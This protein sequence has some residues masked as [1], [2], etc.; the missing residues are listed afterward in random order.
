MAVFTQVLLYIQSRV[1]TWYVRKGLH[2]TCISF[3][4]FVEWL[5]CGANLIKIGQKL[6]KLF[7]NNLEMLKEGRNDR[8]AENSIPP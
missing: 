8:Q 2:C 6:H 4:D 7:N 1:I 3:G 5:R